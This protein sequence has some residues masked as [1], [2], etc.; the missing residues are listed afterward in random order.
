MRPTRFVVLLAKLPQTFPRIIGETMTDKPLTRIRKPPTIYQPDILC[1][2]HGNLLDGEGKNLTAL[3][4]GQ[5]T[6]E[7]IRKRN[8]MYSEEQRLIAKKKAE[9]AEALARGE[10]PPCDCCGS[11]QHESMHHI[12][13]S[14]KYADKLG[15]I[16]EEIKCAKCNRVVTGHMAAKTSAKQQSLIDFF[17]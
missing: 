9:L 5:C 1:P 6:Q 13:Y 8:K 16:Q 15:R 14:S 17:G 3:T 10:F 4:C 2:K 7:V 11:T 12:T